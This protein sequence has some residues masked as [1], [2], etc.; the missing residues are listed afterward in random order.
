[1]SRGGPGKWNHQLGRERKAGR[2]RVSGSDQDCTGFWNNR[3]DS[4][5][6]IVTE[7]TRLLKQ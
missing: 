1:M 6:R 5:G 7:L 2:E 4:I 3:H